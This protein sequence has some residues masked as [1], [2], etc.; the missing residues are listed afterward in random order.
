MA[1]STPMKTSIS[2]SR[3]DDSGQWFAIIGAVLQL[4]SLIGLA[5]TVLGIKRTFESLNQEPQRVVDP[6][7]LSDSIG[8]A[9][10]S[11]GW[12]FAASFLGIVLI[13]VAVFAR[14]YRARW[15]FWFMVVGGALL[16]L[17]FPSSGI[18]GVALLVIALSKR[19]EFII[20]QPNLPKPG[21]L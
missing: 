12:G 3:K 10:I 7:Q 13:C 6:M 1:S 19:H 16:I 4:A 15:L 20:R 2:M 5:G 9:W 8:S 18:F 11:A 17:A 21:F 14:Q